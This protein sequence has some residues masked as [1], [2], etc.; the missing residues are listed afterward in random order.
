MFSLE[1]FLLKLESPSW[2]PKNK[3]VAFFFIKKLELIFN[4]NFLVFGTGNQNLNPD[5]NEQLKTN[6]LI[7]SDSMERC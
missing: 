3:N 2:R 1:G 6:L 4:C 7:R 5:P